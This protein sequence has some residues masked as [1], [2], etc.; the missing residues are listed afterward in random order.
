MKSFID[1]SKTDRLRRQRGLAL[2]LVLWV[3]T[4][5]SLMA[6]GFLSE[7]RTEVRATRNRAEVAEAEA[8]ADAGIYFAISR[9]LQ[10]RTGVAG[11]TEE[12]V[13]VPAD[14]RIL[15]WTFGGGKVR[16]S[17]RDEMGKVDLNAAHPD[18]LWG[19]LQ[20][21]G[22]PRAEARV[23][24]ARILDFRDP[25]DLSRVDGAEDAEYIAAGRTYGAKD[26]AFQSIE[27]IGQVLG[28]DRTLAELLRPHIT[29]ASGVPSVAAETA[30]RSALLALPGVQ[31]AAVD[32]YLLARAETLPGDPP[33]APPPGPDYVRSTQ[34]RYTITAEA[35]TESGA[36]FL[37]EARVSLDRIRAD[38]AY[39]IERWSQ[40]MTRLPA[41]SPDVIA[42]LEAEARRAR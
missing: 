4:L 35:T 17:L 2:V 39:V 30:T 34:T 9:L 32:S 24:A 11:D 1:T 14:G 3:L 5:M 7:T 16:L 6:A 42:A 8:L 18:V 12:P 20:A 26:G 19:L 10:D 27:E 38:Q 29:V 23:I 36:V 33:P 13:P 40:R 28:I 22:V 15:E 25:D 37:R 21:V 31:A 41:Q